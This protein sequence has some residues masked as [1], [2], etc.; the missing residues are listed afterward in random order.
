MGKHIEIIKTACEDIARELPGVETGNL[1]DVHLRIKD[2]AL[3]PMLQP[4]SR[5]VVNNTPNPPMPSKP[6]IELFEESDSF[7]IPWMAPTKQY[8]DQHLISDG[9]DYI[10]SFVNYSRMDDSPHQQERRAKRNANNRSATLQERGIDPEQQLILTTD[11]RVAE[12]IF[13]ALS[14]L[15]LTTRGW[16]VS[17]RYTPPGIQGVPDLIAWKS[18]LTKALQQ[19]G[20]VYKGTMFE[21][22]LYLQESSRALAGPVDPSLPDS[23][24]E[25]LVAEVKGSERSLGEAR[26]QLEKYL[27]S[28][29][30]DH[31]YAAVPGYRDRK[32]DAGGTITCDTRGFQIL[33]DDYNG[34][35]SKTRSRP[36]EKPSY[37]DYM[38][39]AACQALLCNLDYSELLNLY[40]RAA[41]SS[42]SQPND[43]AQVFC[44]L[45]PEVVI[46]TVLEK[47]SSTN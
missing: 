7:P 5:D 15:Y 20:V 33:E 43:L 29:Y 42:P 14:A 11:D 30:F 22:L 10:L 45:E 6:R 19:N 12:S 31:S 41:D 35:E 4:L 38:D 40:Q 36:N 2:P 13:E 21:E 25:T 23:S 18:P 3:V 8:S 47:L 17:K 1:P 27:D 44:G 39:N 32:Q 46:E 37:I 26:G 24:S 28:G 9:R 34:D 16:F